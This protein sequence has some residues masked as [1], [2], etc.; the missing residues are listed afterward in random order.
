MSDP[1]MIRLLQEIRDLQQQQVQATTQLLQN[2]ADAIRSQRDIQAKAR[3]L[4]IPLGLVI[5]VIL[6]IVLVLLRYIL[7]HYA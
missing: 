6:A 3:R 2:Q 1:E 4:L 7:T 5:G